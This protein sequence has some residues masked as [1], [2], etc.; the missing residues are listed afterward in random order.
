MPQLD[1]DGKVCTPKKWRCAR[2]IFQCKRGTLMKFHVEIDQLHTIEIDVFFFR[3][4][5]NTPEKT[6][7]NLA[8]FRVGK[9]FFSI[10]NGY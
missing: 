10:T 6:E 2:G 3:T 7:F 8:Q 9:V 1:S 5:K 4:K